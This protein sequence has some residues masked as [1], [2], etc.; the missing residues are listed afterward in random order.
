MVLFYFAD[1]GVF[2]QEGK[3]SEVAL[4]VFIP[5]VIFI[6]YDYKL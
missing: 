1:F 2:P 4:C 5:R 6:N 3:A